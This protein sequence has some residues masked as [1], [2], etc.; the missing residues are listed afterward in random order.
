MVQR[1]Q[2]RAK[3]NGHN[4]RWG[5]CGVSA[6]WCGWG[7]DHIQLLACSAGQ[8][9]EIGW[10]TYKVKTFPWCST[11]SAWTAIP[12]RKILLAGALCGLGSRESCLQRLAQGSTLLFAAWINF[13]LG[14][15]FWQEIEHESR[16]GIS[17][18]LCCCYGDK[19]EKMCADRCLRKELTVHSVLL[20]L[21]SACDRR[22]RSS[23]WLLAVAFLS[24]QIII[25]FSNDVKLRCG[26]LPLYWP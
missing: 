23:S 19:E 2:M 20:P 7:P 16:F 11:G 17:Y 21:H 22:E 18:C 13:T 4:G 25:S 1:K 12:V 5:F 26:A 9:K 10:E 14:T 3:C 24:Y 8:E 15:R 6:G